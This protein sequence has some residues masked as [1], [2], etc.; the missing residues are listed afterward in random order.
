MTKLRFSDTDPK[1]PSTVLSAT[2]GA[3]GVTLNSRQTDDSSSQEVYLAVVTSGWKLEVWRLAPPP[4]N[5][6]GIRDCSKLFAE[7]KRQSQ[8]HNVG[9]EALGESR[10][11]TEMYFCFL[12]VIKIKIRR[13]HLIVELRQ[14]I[15]FQVEQI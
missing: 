14:R 6:N 1:L 4:T 5:K 7:I 3:K 9:N 15:S 11:L 12:K 10:C 8:V 13:V 2:S